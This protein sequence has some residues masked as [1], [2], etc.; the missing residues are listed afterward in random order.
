MA[1]NLITELDRQ[2]I[3]RAIKGAEARTAGEIYVVIDHKRHEHLAVSFLIAAVAALLVGWPAYVVTTWSMPMILLVQAATF[4]GVSIVVSI[5]KLHRLVVLPSFAA[6][7]ARHTAEAQFMAH[8]IHLTEARTGVLVYVGLADRRVEI[9]ADAG[10]NRKVSQSEWD[11]M[12]R[13]I[14]AAA[15]QGKLA[16][17]IVRVVERAGDLLATHFPALPSDRN[18]LADR[19]VEI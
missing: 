6:D 16:D 11:E 1:H 12:A 3:I 17:G 9:V 19:V 8:G 13:E 14:E 5:P 2:R 10:I 15:R 7:H 18:E 4:A